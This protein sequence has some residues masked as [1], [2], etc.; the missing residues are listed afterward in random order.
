MAG[1]RRVTTPA[2]NAYDT[3]EEIQ[4]TILRL[5][6]RPTSIRPKEGTSLA[7]HCGIALAHLLIELDA[8]A[9]RS[10]ERKPVRVSSGGTAN[11]SYVHRARRGGACSRGV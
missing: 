4:P 6:A 1:S 2:H 11:L 10:A 7:Q 5:A 8:T 3:L 9:S